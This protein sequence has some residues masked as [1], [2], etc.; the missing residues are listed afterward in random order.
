MVWYTFLGDLLFDVFHSVVMELVP[1][2]TEFY[3]YGVT[4]IGKT[5]SA[6]SEGTTD[7]NW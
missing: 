2:A 6:I 1:L 3:L 5:I 7:I 4:S